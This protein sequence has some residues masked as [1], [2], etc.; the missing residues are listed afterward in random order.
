MP[1]VAELIANVNDWLAVWVGE[2]E[3]VTCSCTGKLPVWLGVPEICPEAL[4]VSPGGRL[5]LS[6]D[7]WY[8]VVPP[9]A[10]RVAVYGAL[11][12]PLLND[13][14]AIAKGTGPPDAIVSEYDLDAVCCG[15]PASLAFTVNA[16]LPTCVGVPLIRPV[17]AASVKPAGN[18]PVEI[19]HV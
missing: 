16:L 13:E 9:V 6:S 3:S 2:L 5:P 10:D 15:E 19:D 12:C 17:E 7:Q 1:A 8:G 11:T 4:R 18:A 14:V